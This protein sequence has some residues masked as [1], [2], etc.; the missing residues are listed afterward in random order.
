[1]PAQDSPD[2]A[3]SSYMSD[4]QDEAPLGDKINSILS[5]GIDQVKNPHPNLSN[6]EYDNF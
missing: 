2:I 5:K 4:I 1:M 3:D 6:Q